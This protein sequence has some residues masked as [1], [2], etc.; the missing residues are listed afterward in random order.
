[1]D[2][3][4]LMG[5]VGFKSE[6]HHVKYQYD[7][8]SWLSLTHHSVDLL[9]ASLVA[10]LKRMVCVRILLQPFE[11]RN[12]SVLRIE[13]PLHLLQIIINHVSSLKL[14]KLRV[15]YSFNQSGWNETGAV[16]AD[17]LSVS[18]FTLYNTENQN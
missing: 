10:R 3:H 5:E 9:K 15:S 6:A 13:C 12:L 14:S 8:L 2:I 11:H 17:C 18:R 16:H 4:L 7:V 1:M